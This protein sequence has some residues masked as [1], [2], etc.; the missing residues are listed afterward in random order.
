M[1]QRKEEFEKEEAIRLKK[2]QANE[3]A[4][5]KK[6]EKQAEKERE[7][8]RL[9]RLEQAE[10]RRLEKEQEQQTKTTDTEDENQENKGNQ[11]KNSKGTDDEEEGWGKGIWQIRARHDSV[12]LLVSAMIDGILNGLLISVMGL[13]TW[14]MYLNRNQGIN[15]MEFY[16]YI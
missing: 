1:E 3:K 15:L 9:K 14:Q 4:K 10:K 6:R 8:K 5:A 12:L 16:K 13:F 7:E 2:K 11:K